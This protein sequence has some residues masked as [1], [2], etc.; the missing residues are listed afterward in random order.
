MLKQMQQRLVRARS[1]GFVLF[2]LVWLFFLAR[3]LL[4]FGPDSAYVQYFNSDSALPVLMANDRVIDP[5]RVYI[6]GQDQ[7]GA[8]PFLGAQLLHRAAGFVWTDHSIFI[9]QTIWLFLSVWAV[10]RLCREKHIFSAQLFLCLLCLHFAANR[11]LFVINQRYAW[12]VTALMFAWLYLRRVCAAAFAPDKF[13]RRDIGS[14][15][16]LYLFSLLAIW[17]SPTSTLMLAFV[18]VLE[19]LRAR[20][21]AWQSN[22]NHAGRRALARFAGGVG[23][24]A[25]AVGT[26]ALLR[27]NFY[28]FAVKHY[29]RDYRTP[30]AIDWGHI[31]ENLHRQLHNFTQS[32]WW[33]LTAL[34]VVASMI[35]LAQLLRAARRAPN[36]PATNI[37]VDPFTLD[38]VVLAC[39]SCAFALINFAITILFLWFRLNNFGRRYLALTYLFGSFSGLLFLCLALYLWLP[40]RAQRRFVP[41][42][43]TAALLVLLLIRFPVKLLDPTYAPLKQVATT[44]AQRAPGACVL[45]GYWDT[46]VLAGL[47]PKGTITPVPAEDQYVRTPWTPQ[48]LRE[49]R[50]VIVVQHDYQRFGG[51]AH[52][53]PTIRQHG[54]VLT[55]ISPHWYE[56]DGYT[57]SLYRNESVQ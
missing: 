45:G 55:L 20:V 19:T 25:L 41:T 35:A 9:Y 6:Y 38:T 1:T 28:R 2:A 24:L 52:P 50:E 12:Q 11:Y 51:G 33:P 7:F 47:Q 36:G 49:A 15:L 54:C 10:L 22:A 53:Q 5:F 27:A 13:S 18:F 30:T 21:L 44:L 4:V 40:W 34:A 31:T 42:T 43:L 17:M 16:A 32:T 56:D 46:Y 48:L 37:F 3:A 23:V 8:W 39:G 14:Y 29:G 57:F 26:E